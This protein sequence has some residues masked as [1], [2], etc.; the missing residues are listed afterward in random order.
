[1]R[2]VE[3]LSGA[4]RR[5]VNM[6]RRPR[7]QLTA[8]NAPVRISRGDWG[9][10]PG[11]IYVFRYAL[12]LVYTV[13]WG[14]IGTVLGLIDRSGESVIWVGRN[15]IAWVL[16]ACGIRVAVEGLENVDRA[17]PQVFMCNHQSVIDIAALVMTVPV[18][19][20]FVAKR[21]LARI[22]FFGWALALGGHVL[23]DRGDRT[24]AIRS[25]ERAGHKIRSGTNV[26]VFPE[27]TRS[28]TGE[29]QSFKKGGFHLAVQAQVP[30]VPVTVSGSQR[31]TPKHSLRIESG[32]VKIRYG[33]PIPTAGLGPED[34]DA[35]ADQVRQAILRG[36]DPA[37][38]DVPA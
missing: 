30:I 23:I 4:L 29:L 20:R 21:E 16:A 17:R 24:R 6:H 15:W 3:A 33:K 1:M 8:G 18:S 37:Y 14:S 35:L 27:G 5:A 26:I 12:V 22:P 9:V 36:Y 34:R 19:P 10:K 7:L 28:R 38:Q 25:L 32:E 31:I 2:G 11:L 13:I